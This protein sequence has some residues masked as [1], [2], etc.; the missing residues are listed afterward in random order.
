MA[1]IEQPLKHVSLLQ[2]YLL[3]PDAMTPEEQKNFTQLK[4][5][6]VW[7]LCNKE[8]DTVGEIHLAEDMIGP[9]YDFHNG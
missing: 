9:L 4:I 2:L 7:A 5:I 8:L 1:E 6:S 3:L